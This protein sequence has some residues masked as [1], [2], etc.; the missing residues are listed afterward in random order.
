MFNHVQARFAHTARPASGRLIRRA[1]HAQA[2]SAASAVSHI[3]YDL[4]F[5]A[6]LNRQAWLPS[7]GAVSRL[8]AAELRIAELEKA[9]ADARQLAQMDPLTGALNRRGFEEA[10]QR[11]FARSRRTGAGVALALI[12]L[13]NFKQVNDTLGHQVGDR[14]LVDLVGVLSKAMRPTDVVAR[15][16]G[17]E[18]VLL[19]P[20]TPLL[21]AEAAIQRFQREFAVQ[22]LQ[23]GAC[24]MTFSAGVVTRQ[25]DESLED[26]V[27]RADAATYAAKRAGKNCVV[28]G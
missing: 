10:C 4:A 19:L 13:D 11:E 7:D 18:F 9:L 16:G 24:A 25:S 27:R 1:A 28:T 8:V 21:D 20:E 14:V 26:A 15:F 23:F 5:S 22:S 12:D 17:E 6:S 3:R 2:P